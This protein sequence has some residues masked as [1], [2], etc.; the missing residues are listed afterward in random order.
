MW[1]VRPASEGKKG[2]GIDENVL[3]DSGGEFYSVSAICIV[4]DCTTLWGLNLMYVSY[5]HIP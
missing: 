4:N 5:S 3:G 2:V 1:E